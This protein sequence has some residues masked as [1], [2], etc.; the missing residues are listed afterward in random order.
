[1]L[2]ST[3]SS[4]KFIPGVLLDDLLDLDLSDIFCLFALTAKGLKI[5][6]FILS[7]PESLSESSKSEITG[8]LISFTTIYIYFYIIFT[9]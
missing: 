5:G 9:N 6:D 7:E 4:S 2:F 1:L 3:E 8:N